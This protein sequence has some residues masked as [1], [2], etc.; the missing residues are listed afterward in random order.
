MTEQE[1]IKKL[2]T[3]DNY[4]V[5]FCDFTKMPYAECDEQTF[6]DKAFIF[7]KEAMAKKFVEEYK[8]DGMILSVKTVTR[9][10]ILGF[11]TS[12]P[13]LG[14]N[15]ASFRGNETHNIQLDNIVK[16]QYKEDAPK[17]VENPS[18]QLS[19]IYFM[20]A[21]R[22]AETEEENAIARQFEE[23]MM[24][25]IARGHFLVPS[26]E[27]EETDDEG[28]KK[29]AFLQVKNN[30]GDV[31]IPLFTDIN[32]YFKFNSQDG[33]MKF[34]VLDFNKI[35][36]TKVPQLTGFIINPGTI[37]V[38]LN[39]QHLNAIHQAFGEEA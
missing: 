18:L 31:F 15:M 26:R 34:L 25:N 12:L 28:N 35:Y 7:L 21:V 5:I 9:A 37:S 11:L 19:M 2:P 29:V 38:L 32:E 8:E 4:Y 13:L 6:D 36:N 24:V 22:I 10:E 14:I 1:F 39:E 16:R 20:Q 30:N 33:T 27:I 23:E 17:P 3:I